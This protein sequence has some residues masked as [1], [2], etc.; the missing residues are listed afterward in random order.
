ML[1]AFQ[2]CE[3]GLMRLEW[4]VAAPRRAGEILP[5][6]VASGS[7]WADLVAPEHRDQIE[8]RTRR[9]LGGEPSIDE[10]RLR[11]VAGRAQRVRLYGRPELAGGRVVRIIGAIEEL[12]A[13]LP[14]SSPA[15][16]FW[17]REAVA[18]LERLHAAQKAQLARTLASKDAAL[19]ELRHRLANNLQTA[20]SA[21]RLLSR[22]GPGDNGH[23][24]DDVIKQLSAIA[25]VQRQ[26]EDTGTSPD[27]LRGLCEE[28]CAIYDSDRLAVSVAVE[29]VEIAGERLAVLGMI[30]HEL[31]TNACKHAFPERQPGRL[32]VRLERLGQAQAAL[33][34]GDD[35]V[36]MPAAARDGGGHG[37]QLLATFVQQLQGD[38][39]IAPLSQHPP[40]GTKVRITFPISG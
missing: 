20:I 2:V 13:D 5:A 29:P 11:Q 33:T 10:V 34:V 1:Y 8:R 35:G 39:H 36:G 31:V 38:L 30:V 19:R 14:S 32:E 3:R 25:G 12:E 15:D 18:R 9:L 28:V 16:L 27:Y 4:Q 23:L 22:G 40:R 17:S 7:C 6:Q 24:A 21:V 37:L 26:I